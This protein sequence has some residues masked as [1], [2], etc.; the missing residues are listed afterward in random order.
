MARTLVGAF[1][2]KNPVPYVQRARGYS[3]L[4]TTFI[5]SSGY[6]AQMRALT[7]NGTLFAIVQRTIEGYA[8]VDWR[9][10]RVPRDG[11][12]RYDPGT[13]GAQDNR[14]EVTRHPA[15]DLWRKPNPF[16][17]GVTF[18]QVCQQHEELTGEQYWV[19]VKQGSLVTEMWPV[20]PDR[21]FPVPH[22]TKYLAGY[23]YRSP[24]GEEI[25]LAVEDVIPVR[26]PNPLDIYRGLSA[27][28]SIMTDLDATSQASEYTSA[29]FRNGAAP[30]GVIQAEQNISDEDFDQFQARW[31]ETHQGVNNANRVAILEAGMTWQSVSTTHDEMQ[32]VELKESTRETIREAFG[33]PKA[34]MGSTDDVNKANAYAGE[35]LF[36]RWI[37][38]PR[39]VRVRDALNNF[40][41]PLYGKSAEGLEFD[42]I[43]PVPEDDEIAAQVL[44][45]RAQSAKFL[46]DTGLWEAQS[47]TEVCGLP[48]MEELPEPR[49]P[50]LGKEPQQQDP[51]EKSR[52]ADG[53]PDLK[54]RTPAL[55]GGPDSWLAGLLL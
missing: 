5:S 8:E 36:A 40:L 1:T 18:R 25:P 20:R 2:N 13:A 30:G 43:N 46:A 45:N 39:L 17:T 55:Q 6:E 52:D 23:V 15:L 44:L 47:I 32:L 19:L 29:W 22:P 7:R 12:R 4:T 48:D 49:Q 35:V 11:R 10:Y 16:F 41:L 54:Q 34:M 31:K 3:P 27:V 38:K 9:L 37:V 53:Q 50:V 28:A 42:F 14:V 21:M 51:N 33:F 24:D 26:N